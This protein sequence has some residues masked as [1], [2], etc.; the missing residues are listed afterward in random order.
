MQQTP[1]GSFARFLIGFTLFISV[2][3]GVTLAVQ[4]YAS[5]QD[6]AHQQ[7]AAAAAMLEYKK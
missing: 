1:L 2:S 3:F 6:A 5:G 7:A 4:T